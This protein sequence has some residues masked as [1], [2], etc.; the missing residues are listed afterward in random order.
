MFSKY[1]TAWI[2]GY[3]LNNASPFPTYMYRLAIRL[4]RLQ[5]Q[6]IV[7]MEINVAITQ[8]MFV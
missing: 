3:Y 2:D 8:E 6:W 7:A 5:L 1:H 4:Q